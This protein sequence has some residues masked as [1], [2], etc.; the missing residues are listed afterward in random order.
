MWGM[1]THTLLIE[2]IV[3]IAFMKCKLPLPLTLKE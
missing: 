3:A 2:T 1:D